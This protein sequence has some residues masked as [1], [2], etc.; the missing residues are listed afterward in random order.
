M[1]KFKKAVVGL[2]SEVYKKHKNLDSFD[3]NIYDNYVCSED[4]CLNGKRWD[5][6]G[7]EF[8]NAREKIE[9]CIEILED[10]KVSDF[11]KIIADLKK[12]SKEL[13]KKEQTCDP[14]MELV[15]GWGD[16]SLKFSKKLV[17]ASKPLFILDHGRNDYQIRTTRSG[18][19]EI[20]E[21]DG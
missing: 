19:V 18:S 12:K 9:D 7:E 14:L 15:R 13:I 20:I 8:W 3:F 21:Y 6:Y 10:I 17:L 5:N 2:M 4:I 16:I 11:N 1:D